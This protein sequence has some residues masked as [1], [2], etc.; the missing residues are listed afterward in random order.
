[1]KKN[2]DLLGIGI[3][4][5]SVLSVGAVLYMKNRDQRGGAGAGGG[6]GAALPG[7]DTSGKWKSREQ[8]VFCNINPNSHL[9]RAG[10]D[11]ADNPIQPP[12]PRSGFGVGNPYSNWVFTTQG[13]SLI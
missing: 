6:G 1:M 8:N 7:V 2:Q 10:Y 13:Q 11:W 12:A 9:C 4:G 3:L 5:L